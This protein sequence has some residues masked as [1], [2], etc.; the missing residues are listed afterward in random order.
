MLTFSVTNG[1][2]ASRAKSRCTSSERVCTTSQSI[3][4][5]RSTVRQRCVRHADASAGWYGSVAEAIN[6]R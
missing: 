6:T 2:A 4:W 5:E 1:S 3:G